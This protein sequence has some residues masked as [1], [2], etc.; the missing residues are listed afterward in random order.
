MAVFQGGHRGYLLD[1]DNN[2]RESDGVWI[3]NELPLYYSNVAMMGTKEA[4]N[5]LQFAKY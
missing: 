5:E 2:Q 3:R 1:Y 4:P